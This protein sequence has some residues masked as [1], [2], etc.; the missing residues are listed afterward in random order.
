MSHD[1]SAIARPYAKAVYEFATEQKKV[2]AWQKTLQ[3][4]AAFFSDETV[5]TY[6]HSPAVSSEDLADCAIKGLKLDKHAQNFVQLLAENHRLAA[7][8]A[9]ATA[10]AAFYSAE[11]DQLSGVLVSALPV[12]KKAVDDVK[13]ALQ[14]NLKK[15]I[16]LTSEVDPELIGGALIRV[17]DVVIDGS[18]KGKLERLTRALL[19]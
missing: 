18:I 7:L 11:Q 2:A 14:D 3:S 1:F 4:L 15:T 6:L 5:Q 17:G 8:P 16:E 13:K 12:T 9:I 10:F 19:K